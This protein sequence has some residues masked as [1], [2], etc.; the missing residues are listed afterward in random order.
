MERV[1]QFL[2]D[3]ASLVTRGRR[4]TQVRTSGL[5]GELM[6]D[7]NYLLGILGQKLCSSIPSTPLQPTDE[8]NGVQN[9]KKLC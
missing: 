4:G 8:E 9:P 7:V 1:W 3:V 6:S 5:S 2:K